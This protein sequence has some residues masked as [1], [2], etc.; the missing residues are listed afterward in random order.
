MQLHDQRGEMTQRPGEGTKWVEE[1]RRMGASPAWAG[2]LQRH[3]MPGQSLAGA[4]KPRAR[5]P[6]WR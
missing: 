6:T 3:R 2:E 4:A 1:R 5:M